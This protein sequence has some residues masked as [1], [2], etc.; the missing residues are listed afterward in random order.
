MAPAASNSNAEGYQTRLTFI[1]E[2]LTE[3]YHIKV[4]KIQPVAYEADFPFPYNNFVYLVEAQIQADTFQRIG[5]QYGTEPVPTDASQFIVRLPNPVSGYNDQ[6]RVENEVASLALGRAA[7]L[8]N[9]GTNLVARVFA[10]GS[11]KGGHQG[12]IVQ[13]YMPGQPL[14]QDFEAM[15]LDKQKII[16]GQMADVIGALQRF[17]VPESIKQ[18]GGLT[19]TTDGSMVSSA[20][21]ILDGGPF[22]TYAELVLGTIRSKLTK[23]DKNSHIAGWHANGVRDRLETFLMDGYPGLMRTATATDKRLVHADLSTDNL[24]YDKTTLKV[25]ALIDFDFAHIATVADEFFRSLGFGIGTFPD[26]M[27]GK[28][29]ATLNDAM[30]NGF[31]EPLPAATDEIK[32][33][34]AKAWDDALHDR[35]LY[36]PSTIPGLTTLS[37]LFWLS[38]QLLPFKLVHPVVVG[39]SSEEQLS[40]RRADGEKLLTEFLSKHG[41]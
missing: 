19:Y 26:P 22:Q 15:E 33:P 28:E 32:W 25:T 17:D 5:T 1:N 11:A 23:A 2:L 6:V 7:L 36:R 37:E 4:T 40:D 21:S 27:E 14:A 12:W 29:A 30:L 13:E 16:L 9:D 38:S 8:R 39:N 41:Y 18:Y 24:L 31:P 3:R 10:W 34:Q 35:G 20:M